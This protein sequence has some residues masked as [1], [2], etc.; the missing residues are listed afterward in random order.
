M[1]NPQPKQNNLRSEKYLE[2]IRT[3][4]C[5]NCEHPE[6]IAHHVLKYTDGGKGLKPSDY[7]TVPLC[8]H[9][10]MAIHDGHK[11]DKSLTLVAGY[12]FGY[13]E[14]NG[15]YKLINDHLRAIGVDVFERMEK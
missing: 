1:S 14:T 11:P 4:T 2:W 10:H 5:A 9:C 12:Q 6:T 7:Y 15:H 13:L 8:H 3:H